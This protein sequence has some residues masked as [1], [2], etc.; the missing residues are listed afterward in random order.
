MLDRSL[1]EE[2]LAAAL[3][4]GGDFAEVFVEERG[5][6]S[7]RLDDGK[8]EGFSGGIDRGAAVRVGH[9]KA[10]GYAFSNRLDRDALMNAAAAAAA[11]VLEDGKTVVHDLREIEPSVVHRAEKPAG[12]VPSETK[13]SWLREADETARAVDPSVR[14]VTATYADSLQRILI[15]ASDGRWVEEERPRIRLAVQVVASRDGI[16]QTGF[17]GPAGLAGAEFVEEHT[18]AAVA[19]RSAKQAVTMLDSIPAPAGE[20]AVVMSPGTGG[21]LFHEACGH[22]LEA[23]LVQKDASIYKGRLGETLASP[24]VTGVDDATV[25]NAWGSFSFD[26]EGSPA[27]RTVL[28]EG[29]DLRTYLYD[30]LRA[31]VDGVPSSGNGRRQSYAHP[32]IPRM[33]NTYILAGEADPGD[34]IGSTALGLYT[35]SLGGGQ[36]DPATGDF[37]F[38]VTE[39]YLIENGKLTKPVRGANLVGRGVDILTA[40]D[41]VAGDFETWEGVCGKDGQG[42]PVGSGSPTLRISRM[43]VGG[44]G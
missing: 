14:Q 10:F 1:S 7:A 16:I 9:G 20:M 28:F 41:A 23:D 34:V 42:V 29:G 18:P 40:I 17:Y 43:T 5:S 36:V 25:T 35:K 22:G 3:A 24:L 39:G 4:R 11:S 19:E 13:V 15:A 33:T 38:G 26:D 2:V 21:V 27:Q 31:E 44:T 37:V 6:V 32:P 12:D 30:R 8:I